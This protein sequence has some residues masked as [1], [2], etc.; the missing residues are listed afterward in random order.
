MPSTSPPVG[1]DTP[2]GSPL[3]DE[4]A[5]ERLFRERYA[6]L[7]NEAKSHLK[8]ATSA[9][10]RIVE[11]LFLRAWD[12]RAQFKS[13]ADLDAF[14]NTEVPHAA[15][16]ELARRASAHHFGAQGKHNNAHA[17]PALDVNQSWERIQ[18][19]LHPDRASKEGA[20]KDLSR[21]DTA[22]HVKGLAKRRNYTLPVVIV[23]LAIA[24]AFGISKYL[25]SLSREGGIV[26]ALKT[27]ETSAHQTRD[28]QLANVD[29]NDGSK[30]RMGP[31]SKLVVADG[32][33]D[34][35]RAIRV[36]G[37]AAVTVSP[38]RKAPLQVRTG[39]L[40]ITAPAGMVIVQ[41]L[42]DSSVTLI[43]KG[44]GDSLRVGTVWQPLATGAAMHVTPAGT[45]STASPAQFMEASTWV[46]DTL[47]LANR[48]LK[49][50]VSAIKEWYGTNIVVLDSTLLTRP[51]T[52]QATLTAA[53]A[54]ISAVE[55]SANVKFGYEGQGMVF[56]DAKR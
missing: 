31:D 22:S 14:F 46:N 3:S 5:L 23:L 35:M 44:D 29:L 50:A 56:R 47:S 15:A 10:P 6:S 18:K 13:M 8:D 16:R 34:D 12:E 17:E 33:G 9:A 28:A 24:V 52:I 21:H 54:A 38:G 55:K 48:T 25:N 20:I 27:G 2:A 26:A 37:V 40:V 53:T 43:A 19:S 39:N 32:F 49:E 45:V 51:V 11:A 36:E 1:P 7:A 4:Q 41:T 42:D 30:V